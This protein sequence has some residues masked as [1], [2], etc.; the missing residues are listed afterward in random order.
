MENTVLLLHICCPLVSNYSETNPT[1]SPKISKYKGYYIET[2]SNVMRRFQMHI[3]R[4]FPIEKLIDIYNPT[5]NDN[6]NCP[7]FNDKWY[8]I[9]WIEHH[10][11]AAKE[12]IR[13]KY[14]NDCHFESILVQ[15]L[16]VMCKWK[17]HSQKIWQF[18][19]F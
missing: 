14:W 9:N 16:D 6:D 11:F 4:N 15:W 8:Q 3:Y 10:V 12:Q 5:F 1:L 18:I 2:Q 19:E 13:V 17:V 7:N